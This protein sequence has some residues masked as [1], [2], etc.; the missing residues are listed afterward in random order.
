MTTPAKEPTPVTQEEHRG[1]SDKDAVMYPNASSANNDIIHTETRAMGADPHSASR[2]GT[3]TD[4]AS[5]VELYMSDSKMEIPYSTEYTKE[6]NH[7]ACKKCMEPLRMHDIIKYMDPTKSF[8]PNAVIGTTVLKVC[9]NTEQLIVVKNSAF[10]PPNTFV[11]RVQV[12]KKGNERRKGEYQNHS[13]GL[14]RELCCFHLEAS[15][16]AEHI[17]AATGIYKQASQC[18]RIIK[19]AKQQ[20]IK[21]VAE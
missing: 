8:G 2:V 11:K 6:H 7:S 20:L 1:D 19:Q 10:L 9:P 17:S 4:T 12:W 18:G 16:G 13:Y 3:I 14:L 5:D 15:E 21:Q